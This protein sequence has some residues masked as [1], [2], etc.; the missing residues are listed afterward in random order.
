M[1]SFIMK[2][3]VC[4]GDDLKFNQLVTNYFS[5]NQIR[6]IT[7]NGNVKAEQIHSLESDVLLIDLS[8]PN[9]KIKYLLAKQIRE[10]SDIPVLFTSSKRNDDI[11]LKSI[12][13][14]LADFIRKPVDMVEMVA[15]MNKLI[16]STSKFNNMNKLKFGEAILLLC[17]QTIEYE[18]KRIHLSRME[19]K[20]LY[21]LYQHRNEYIE[22]NTLVCKI[23]EITDYKL[24]KGTFGNI[25]CKIRKKIKCIEGICIDTQISSKIKLIIPE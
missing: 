25:L 1:K 6:V 17:E 22:R 11:T 3:V 7:Q 21:K 24:R 2:K 13:F 16:T 9:E 14:C 23:W 15:R 12:N 18:E 10:M 20:I 19:T 5:E 4:I 8:S